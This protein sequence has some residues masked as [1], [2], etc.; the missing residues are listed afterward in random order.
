[1]EDMSETQGTIESLKAE[2]SQLQSKLIKLLSNLAETNAASIEE[3]KLIAHQLQEVQAA[4]DAEYGNLTKSLALQK[5][6]ELK[7]H[8]ATKKDRDAKQRAINS[9]EAKLA[10]KTDE[11]EAEVTDH[12][13]TK[14]E[15]SGAFGE[16][17]IQKKEIQELRDMIHFPGISNTGDPSQPHDFVDR[18]ELVFVHLKTY[19]GFVLRGFTART[20]AGRPE[21]LIKFFQKATKYAA[22]QEYNPEEL[23]IDERLYR[24]A[25][26]IA[27]MSRALFQHYESDTFDS[28]SLSLPGP[29]EVAELKKQRWK[30]RKEYDAIVGTE[31]SQLKEHDAVATWFRGVIARLKAALVDND[32]DWMQIFESTATESGPQLWEVAKHVWALHKLARTYALLPRIIRFPAFERVNPE[33]CKSF[34]HGEAGVKAEAKSEY[35]VFCTVLPGFQLDNN[36][37]SCEVLWV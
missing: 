23:P 16:I 33:L 15:L 35:T 26:L 7:L 10:T 6:N 22:N 30:Y 34:F 25:I 5:E 3:A 11:L 24:K 21:D 19:S 9:L 37:T 20:K 32:E 1:L 31:A 4:L 29:C 36:P 28:E 27:A 14:N 13:Q 8:D 12:A 17:H 18:L 2:Y